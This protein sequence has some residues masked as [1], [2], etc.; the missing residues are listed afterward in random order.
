[1]LAA[2]SLQKSFQAIFVRLHFIN[3]F[4]RIIPLQDEKSECEIY[5]M[6]YSFTESIGKVD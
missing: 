5:S 4:I 6:C 2:E 1:M 3:C